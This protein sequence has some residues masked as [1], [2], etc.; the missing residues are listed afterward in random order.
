MAYAFLHLISAW[1]IGKF[2]ETTSKF[3]LNSHFWLFLL[4]GSILPDADLLI[5]WTFGTNLHRTFTHSFFFVFFAIV[6]T[7]I[8]LELYG[9]NKK[10]PKSQPLAFALYTGILVHILVD[11][12]TKQGV[13]IFWPLNFNFSVI[14]LINTNVYYSSFLSS[15]DLTFLLVDIILGIVWILFLLTRKRIRF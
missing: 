2:F 9:Y 13:K 3:K 14:E 10:N 1:I 5:D 12:F 6:T 15:S 7:F 4:V 11:L 8:I